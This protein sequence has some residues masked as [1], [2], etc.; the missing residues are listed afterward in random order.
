[1]LAW[2]PINS[3]NA[4]N[5]LL[6]FTLSKAE[7]LVCKVFC[8]NTAMPVPG[9]VAIGFTLPLYN[10]SLCVL[11]NLLSAWITPVKPPLTNPAGANQGAL[12]PSVNA[13]VPGI[14]TEAGTQQLLPVAD[15]TCTQGQYVAA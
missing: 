10:V 14:T 8:P 15:N 12:A 11:V 5:N 2:L 9:N 7:A 13:Y 4:I 1:M 3:F 6:T